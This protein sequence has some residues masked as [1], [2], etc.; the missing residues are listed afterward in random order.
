MTSDFW[1]RIEALA[2]IIQYKFSSTGTEIAEDLSDYDWQN[3]IYTGGNYRRAHLQIIDRRDT[4]R[5]YIVHATVFPHYNDP[6]PIF[7]FDIIAGAG[8]I[9]GAFLDYSSAGDPDHGMIQWFHKHVANYVWDR[10]RVL[11]DWAKAIFSSNMLAVGNIRDRQELGDFCALSRQSLDYYLKNIGKTEQ[12]GF[13]F[14]M[15]QNRYCRYQK[16]NPHVVRSMVSMGVPE[17][18]IRYFVD[19]VMFPE[20]A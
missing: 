12:S 2:S 13:D 1:D 9:T 20:A 7:G 16:Q 11:P 14:H 8:K 6:S 19:K 18:Q 10:V 15:A 17:P 3:Y 5:V 4:H